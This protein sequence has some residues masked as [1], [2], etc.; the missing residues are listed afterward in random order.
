[1]L[2]LVAFIKSKWSR[3]SQLFYSTAIYSK[4]NIEVKG[5]RATKSKN[6]LRH[7]KFLIVSFI[8]Y[9]FHN[10][11]LENDTYYIFHIGNY[12]QHKKDP[13]GL[14]ETKNITAVKNTVRKS[15]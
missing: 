9:Q 1:M 13:K 3:N 5:I 11:L 10:L 6:K 4:T 12:I 14:T 2:Y 7:C 15:H 8:T